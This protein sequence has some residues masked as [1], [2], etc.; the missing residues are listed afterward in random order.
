MKLNNS[1]LYSVYKLCNKCVKIF[2]QELQLAVF[3]KCLSAINC[4]LVSILRPNG[5]QWNRVYLDGR[6]V[7]RDFPTIQKST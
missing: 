2:I 3:L 6:H 7:S 5:L 1:N 4:S